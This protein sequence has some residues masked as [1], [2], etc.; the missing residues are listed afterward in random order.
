M[1]FIIIVAV[2]VTACT[3]EMYGRSKS[4]LSDEDIAD[5]R[6]KELICAMEDKNKEKIKGMISQSTVNSVEKLESE[7]QDLI[8]F[9]QGS[10]ISFDNFGGP[11]VTQEV[12]EGNTKIE[13]E[14]SYLVT[15]TIKSYQIA[16]KDI[17]MDDFD[18]SNEGINY[19]YIKD[20]KDYDK[21]DYVYW[22]DGEETPGINI[23]K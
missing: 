13:F 1:V 10:F 20:A 15:T 22:G 16:V 14:F 19:I 6:M 3:G 7:I 2:S 11:T 23:E 9:Y 12:D 5:D 18:T 8:E 4:A 17:I 21:D